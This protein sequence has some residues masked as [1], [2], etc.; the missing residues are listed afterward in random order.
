MRQQPTAAPVTD[1]RLD[2]L[3]SKLSALDTSIASLQES[4]THFR[5]LQTSAASSSASQ[6]QIAVPNSQTEA[7]I[8][9]TKVLIDMAESISF[10]VSTAASRLSTAPSFAWDASSRIDEDLASLFEAA[11]P[12][13]SQNRVLS[14]I[15][16]QADTTESEAGVQSPPSTAASPDIWTRDGAS[17]AE[18][19]TTTSSPRSG[20]NPHQEFRNI[21]LKRAVDYVNRGETQRAIRV[22]E[23]LLDQASKSPALP[24]A[25]DIYGPYARAIMESMA[26]R[27][28]GYITSTITKYPGVES[29]LIGL[30]VATVRK[31]LAQGDF[32]EAKPHIMALR[33]RWSLDATRPVGGRA[34]LPATQP[35]PG[36]Q[37]ELDIAL[38]RCLLEELKLEGPDPRR[39]RRR[40]LSLSAE[41]SSTRIESPGPQ[42]VRPRPIVPPPPTR[43]GLSR[44]EL[45]TIGAEPENMPAINRDKRRPRGFSLR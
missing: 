40:K 39:V 27:H 10:N 11:L 38:A 45:A 33:D 23:E 24:P 4:F 44:V 2:L 21:K 20:I 5:S 31:L 42:V 25:T 1:F 13:R 22:F 37:A 6:S 35:S 3:S 19:T 8:R 36:L 29:E 15:D 34:G 28:P 16:G 43:E 18:S 41:R 26:A 12:N 17:A 14:W 30:S 9:D 7:T 32:R